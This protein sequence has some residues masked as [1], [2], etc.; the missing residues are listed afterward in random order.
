MKIIKTTNID[1]CI[2][3]RAIAIAAK[4]RDIIQETDAPNEVNAILGA[5]VH[6]PRVKQTLGP[7]T[8]YV[9]W[10]AASGALVA[11]HVTAREKTLRN[12]QRQERKFGHLRP[13]AGLW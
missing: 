4:D 11:C 1:E 3:D 8:Y 6:D 9:F 10:L 12:F 13:E 2:Y 7:N 5:N